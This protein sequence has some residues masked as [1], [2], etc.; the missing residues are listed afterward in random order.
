MWIE[1]L[2]MR[3]VIGHAF[4]EERAERRLDRWT[5]PP[6]W[7]MLEASIAIENGGVDILEED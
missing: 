5:I 1:C 6:P 4:S 2:K 3:R 7:R